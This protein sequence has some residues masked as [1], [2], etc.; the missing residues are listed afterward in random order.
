MVCYIQ[1]G[2]LT[3]LDRSFDTEIR[4]RLRSQRNVEMHF[5]LKHGSSK[6]CVVKYNLGI[7]G[8]ATQQP[9]RI[10]GHPNTRLSYD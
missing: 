5:G 1:H 10:G 3:I 9:K 4:Q 8:S 2:L 7:R 6:S